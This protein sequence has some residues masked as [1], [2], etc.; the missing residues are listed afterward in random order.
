M[1][2]GLENPGDPAELCGQVKSPMTTCPQG[3]GQTERKLSCQDASSRS[4][5]PKDSPGAKPGGPTLASGAQ[6]GQASR[7]DR[8]PLCGS[9]TCREVGCI[10]NWTA[11]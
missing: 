1:V 7:N 6:L 2:E 5:K 9:S 8:P 11:V 10:A 3:R 4:G